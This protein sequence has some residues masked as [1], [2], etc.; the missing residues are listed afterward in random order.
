MST[1]RSAGRF[2]GAQ[3]DAFRRLNDSISFDWRLSPYDV[4]QSVAHAAMLAE[5]GIISPEDGA[6]LQRASRSCAP[7]WPTARSRSPTATR[8]STWRSSAG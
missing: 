1:G 7:S 2:T 6:E 3:A 5:Q 4:D 8:T